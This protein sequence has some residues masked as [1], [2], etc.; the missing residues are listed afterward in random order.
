[1]ST[2]NKLAFI[3]IAIC[4]F[5]FFQSAQFAFCQKI[6]QSDNFDAYD[7]YY[8]NLKEMEKILQKDYMVQ[9]ADIRFLESTAAELNKTSYT[10]LI[11]K[12]RMLLLFAQERNEHIHSSKKMEEISEILRNDQ[13]RD[14]KAKNLKKARKITFGTALVSI[15]LFNLF[16]YLADLTFEKYVNATTVERSAQL[17]NTTELL[18][19]V[20]Y[21]CGGVGVISLGVTIHLYAKETSI[22]NYYDTAQ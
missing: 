9:H 21:I 8:E 1:M 10:D 4:I 14:K 20:S 18:D 17:R 3:L 2:K 22:N 13:I 12:N 11:A 16:W 19:A 15:G 6:G 5:V 7:V